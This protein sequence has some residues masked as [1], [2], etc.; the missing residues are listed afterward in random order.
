MIG[1]GS[2]IEG[3]EFWQEV[4]PDIP[5]KE[6]GERNQSCPHKNTKGVIQRQAEEMTSQYLQTNE[7]GSETSPSVQV[8]AVI[9]WCC[10]LSR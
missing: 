7:T 3:R 4:D 8:G 6:E 2:Y 9:H 5:E 10:Y 1:E